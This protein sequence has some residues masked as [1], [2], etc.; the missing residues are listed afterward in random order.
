M[1]EAMARP[2]FADRLASPRAFHVALAIGAL[3]RLAHVAAISASPLADSAILDHR[4]YD[5]WAQR[6]ADGAWLGDG[7][8]WVDPLYAYV[9]ALV[10]KVFGHHFVVVRVL[11]AAAGVGIVGLTRTL[12]RRVSGS[13][14]IANGAA[15]MAA[16]Y[17]PLIHGEA[18]L[19]KATLSTLLATGALAAYLTPTLRGDTIAGLLTGLAVLARGNFLLAIPAGIAALLL[20]DPGGAPTRVIAGRR[21]GEAQLQRAGRY[22]AVSLAIVGAVTL[23]NAAVGHDL[24]L[25]TANAGQN[26]YIGQARENLLGTYTAPSFLRPDPAFEEA[27]F[28]AEGDRR[29]GRPM[30]AS[31]LSRYWATQGLAEIAAAPGATFFRTL[32]KLRLAFADAEIPDDDDIGLAASWSP[33]LRAPLLSMGLVAPLALLGVIVSWRRSRGARVV[34]GSVALYAFGLLCFFIV[35]RFRLPMVPGLVVLAAL[36][37]AWLAAQRSP[38]DPRRL[39]G[40]AVLVA[41]CAYACLAQPPW[42]SQQLQK[43]LAIGHNNVASQLMAQNRIPEAMASYEEAIAIAPDSV[44]GAMRSL[45]DLYVR[46]QRY[47]DAER[48]MRMVLERKP[49]SAMGRSALAHLY[50]LMLRD[51]RWANDSTVRARAAALGGHAVAPPRST[52]AAMESSAP[53]SVQGLYDRVRAARA[54]GRWDEAIATLEEAIRTGA[55]NENAR[56][57]LGQL[58]EAHASGDAMIAYFEAARATD[59]KPQTSLYFWGIGLEK[60]GKLDQA[61]GK[62]TEALAVDPAHEMSELRWCQLLAKRGDKAGALRHCDRA[63][64]IFPDLRAAHEERARLLD[65]LGRRSDADAARAAAVQSN[66]NTPKGPLYWGRYLFKVGRPELARPELERAVHDDPSDAE[67]ASLLAQ[68]QGGA[69]KPA[70]PPPTKPFLDAE[71]RTAMEDVLATAPPGSPLW[72]LSTSADPRAA[73][74]AGEIASEFA[75]GGW[76]VRALGTTPVR[77]KPGVFMFIADE[78]AP[79]YV[80]V[81]QKGL[82]AAGLAPGVSG[83][84]RKYYEEMSTTTAGFQGFPMSAEQTFFIVVGRQP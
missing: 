63:V 56:Y 71:K 33:V 35:G 61:I 21:I 42:L 82:E 18:Q 7:V 72:I 59:P 55:Y 67:A 9:L 12:G 54:A 47:E 38:A 4:A 70:P 2:S 69:K 36:A 13:A 57:L 79:G 68:V 62:W 40:A 27:D 34:A 45:G 39:G 17:L 58:M 20:D 5:E 64:E 31:E 46:A 81:A 3:L 41:A 52:S 22:A 15:L 19:E 43:S 48:V 75:L 30:K 51:P 10:Y 78:Q 8:F 11:Q 16:I 25:T 50:D 49:D 60:Q 1:Q 28:R 29:S 83:G 24:V 76:T 66:P 37:V 14:A 26:F 53:V 74:L 80:G 44:V 77:V 65:A 32:R 84:Y 23:R 6:I 73:L